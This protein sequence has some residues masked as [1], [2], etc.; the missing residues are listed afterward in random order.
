MFK[1]EPVAKKFY[2]GL[3]DGKFLG[4][5]C[6]EC[7]HIEFPPYPACNE[8]GHYGNEWIDLTDA[9]VTVDEIYAISPMM[10]IEDFMPYAPLFSCEAHMEG[11]IEFSCLIFGV[12]KKEYKKI[13]AIVP[14]KGRLVVMPMD[15][16][17][18]LAVSINGAVPLRKENAG[19]TVDRAEV[20]KAISKDSGKAQDKPY[21][22][23]DGKYIFKLEMMGR[24]RNGSMTVVAND[25]KLTGFAEAMDMQLDVN[26]TIDDKKHF[27]FTVE[28][29]GTELAFSGD[30]AEDRSLKGIVKFGHMKMKLTGG[31]AD[32]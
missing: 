16:Y 3:D 7:G 22:G 12:S 5:K 6:S 28:A 23:I 11:G 25:G 20:L 15:G 26:G 27:E 21:N 17:N 2:D 18:S 8:C 9:E 13:R 14:L 19:H 31:P 1:Y 29:K 32:Q 4:L 10:T 30:I 24:E